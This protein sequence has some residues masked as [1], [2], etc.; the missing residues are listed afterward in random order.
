MHTSVFVEP[1]QKNLGAGG[2]MALDGDEEW[3]YFRVGVQEATKHLATGYKI[4]KNFG[5]R[6]MGAGPLALQP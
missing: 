1:H 2:D 6:N 5:P 4:G 3:A